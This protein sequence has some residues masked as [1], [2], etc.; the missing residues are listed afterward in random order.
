[1]HARMDKPKPIC[2]PLFK[3][4]GILKRLLYSTERYLLIVDKSQT[5]VEIFFETLLMCFAHVRFLSSCRPNTFSFEKS[6][7]G[8]CYMKCVLN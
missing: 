3:V 4:G 8:K 5:L 1:M 6:E 2:S 7:R